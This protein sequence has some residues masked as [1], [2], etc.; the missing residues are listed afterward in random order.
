MKDKKLRNNP[1]ILWKDLLDLGIM[2][3]LANLRKKQ[4]ELEARKELKESL[5]RQSEEHWQ[6]LCKVLNDLK[7]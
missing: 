3:S 5:F 2:L 7:C 6:G 4:S 1:I